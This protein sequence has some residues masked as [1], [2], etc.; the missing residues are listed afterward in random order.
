MARPPRRK[1][2]NGQGRPVPVKGQP[3]VFRIYW[4]E[5]GRRRSERVRGTPAD[6]NAALARRRLDAATAAPAVDGTVGELVEHWLAAVVA[7]SLAPQTR[8]L[9]GT[10]M[11]RHVLPHLGPIRASELDPGG[12][13]RWL[14]KLADLDVGTATIAN[15]FRTFRSCLSH[16]VGKG[17]LPSHPMRGVKR[18]RHDAPDVRPFTADELARLLPAADAQPSGERL[19]VY[20][21]LLLTS[22]LRQGEANAL[23]WPAIDLQRG[24]VRVVASQA[25]RNRTLGPPKS[26][27]GK[28]TVPLTPDTA[29]RLAAHRD[30]QRGAGLFGAGRT[31][32]TDD[33]KPLARNVLHPTW[34]RVCR[35]AGVEP[36]GLHHLRHTYATRLLVAGVPLHE[37]SRLIGHADVRMT[38]DA[39]AH[40]MPD[41]LDR[42]RDAA[43]AAFG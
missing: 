2:A 27:A 12:V 22:G 33:G 35:D 26:K 39:Y 17:D 14:K 21:R 28:R 7:T 43:A 6:A 11:R 13:E 41:T 23:D 25:D 20:V 34:R 30:R 42:A 36:R 18:P 8:D 10:L 19:G 4:T 32:T 40:A 5:G 16:A 31:F 29:N 38:L 1:S 9:Y 15:V 3:G 24:T 37:V